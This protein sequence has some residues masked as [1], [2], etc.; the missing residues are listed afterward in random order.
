MSFTLTNEQIEILTLL[1]NGV[2]P[3]DETDLGAAEVQ[4]GPVIASRINNGSIHS[5]V[6]LQ[7]IEA[8]SDLAQDLYGCTPNL[9]NAEQIYEVL[10]ELRTLTPPFYKQLRLDVSA[11]YLSDPA[12]WERIGFP[13]PSSDKGGYPDF[14]QPQHK[15][16]TQGK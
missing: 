13:G 9:M 8:A 7:G 14:D 5:H 11:L 15:L 10:L 12:V 16:K 6:Y 3:A 1:A 4:A 2:I